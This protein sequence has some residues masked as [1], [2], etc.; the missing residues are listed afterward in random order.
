MI[1]YIF[2]NSYLKS[3]F[4]FFIYSFNFLMFIL[5]ICLVKELSII[6]SNYFNELTNNLLTNQVKGSSCGAVLISNQ[7]ALTAAHCLFEDGRLV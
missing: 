2:I 7:F 3:F 1:I 4:V 6:Q 5:F